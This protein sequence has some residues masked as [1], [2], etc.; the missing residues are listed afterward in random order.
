MANKITMKINYRIFADST[1]FGGK[2]DPLIFLSIY[3]FFLHYFLDDNIANI[4][5]IIR[6]IEVKVNYYIYLEKNNFG[7]L[8]LLEII[9]KKGPLDFLILNHYLKASIIFSCFRDTATKI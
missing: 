9:Y 7:H 4:I 1:N 5:A 2:I 8:I 3:S 6:L